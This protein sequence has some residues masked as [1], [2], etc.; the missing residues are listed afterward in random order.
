MI[1]GIAFDDDAVTNPLITQSTQS[2]RSEAFRSLRTNLQFVDAASH[3]RSIVFTSSLPSEGKTT[4]TAN[5][6]ITLA[7][8]G[9]KVCVVEADLRR[10]RLLAYMGMEGSVGLTSVLIGQAELDDVLQTF[11]EHKVTVLGA[12]PIPPIRVNSWVR[13]P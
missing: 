4:T 9:A 11:G 7:A 13:R 8:G 2:A 6:A 10:P 3:P 12:G 5:L 1:G